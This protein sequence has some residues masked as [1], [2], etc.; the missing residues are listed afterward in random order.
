MTTLDYF[1]NLFQEMSKHEL[2]NIVMGGEFNL[3]MNSC[4][5]A[6]NINRKNNNKAKAVLDEWC[7]LTMLVDVF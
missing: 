3:V 2:T 7:E 6:T 5:D 1:V 4:L